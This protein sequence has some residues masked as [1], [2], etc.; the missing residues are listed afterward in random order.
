MSSRNHNRKKTTVRE[1]KSIQ[2]E[3]V[4]D[5]PKKHN[6]SQRQPSSVFSSGV[7]KTKEE[8]HEYAFEEAPKV[9]KGNKTTRDISRSLSRSISPSLTPKTVV[10]KQKK[11]ETSQQVTQRQTG[12]KS[13]SKSTQQSDE[14][15]PESTKKLKDLD[16]TASS[17]SRFK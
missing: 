1:Q 9:K 14:L 2:T 6:T 4:H 15:F 17:E 10:K 11:V 3:Q 12:E 5:K 13:P 8:R 16:T 7:K